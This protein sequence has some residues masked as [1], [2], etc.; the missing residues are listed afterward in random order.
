MTTSAMKSG[1]V[2]TSVVGGK[3]RTVVRAAERMVWLTGLYFG[4]P[5]NPVTGL[6]VGYFVEGRP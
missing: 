6:P 5:I 1:D 3:R 4:V 2:V